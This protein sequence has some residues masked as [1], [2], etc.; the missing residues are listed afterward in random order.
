MT[1]LDVHNAA[2]ESKVASYHEFMTR[3]SKH[4]KVVYGFVE[5]KE[6]PCFYR[7]FIESV[8][9]DDWEV[10]LWA[11][12]SRD[13][14]YE[15][16]RSLNWRR[17]SKRRICFFVDRDLR[18]MIPQPIEEDTNIYVTKGY[19]IENDLVCKHTC[20]R[21]LT[22]L[23]DLTDA[24][25]GEME[26]VCEMFEEQLER[27]LNGMIPVMGWILI[28]RRNGVPA[29][30]N[31]L[32]MKDLFSFKKGVIHVIVEPTRGVDWATHIHK[33]C[34]LV[35]DTA[36]N[37]QGAEEEFRQVS[38]DSSGRRRNCRRQPC[39]TWSQRRHCHTWTPYWETTT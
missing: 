13:Q 17:M 9:P 34:N 1:M 16:H 31:D 36:I 28:W 24:N 39:R 29:Q 27:F 33:K 32:A 14:V 10:E 3:Y 15:I 8:L 5:G 35:M 25:H 38:S 20:K 11:A 22:E 26:R 23:C 19:S 18:E 2:R 6:D 4:A 21:V 12:G 7:G 30:L 37:P